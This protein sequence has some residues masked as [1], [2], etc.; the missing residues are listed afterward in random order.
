MG[1]IGGYC[2]LGFIVSRDTFQGLVGS[3]SAAGEGELEF[4]YRGFRSD[5]EAE[6]WCMRRKGVAWELI[7]NKSR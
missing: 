2:F 7:L 4:S 5:K 3:D 1:D 6:V